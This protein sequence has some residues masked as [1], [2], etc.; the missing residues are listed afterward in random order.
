MLVAFVAVCLGIAHLATRYAPLTA[1]EVGTSVFLGVL[2]HPFG[3]VVAGDP[4]MVFYPVSEA[5]LLD[6]FTPLTATNLDHTLLLLS[7]ELA[8]VWGSILLA[9]VLTDRSV[10]PG[11]GLAYGTAAVV[12]AAVLQ[13]SS[14][15]YY[16]LAVFVGGVIGVVALAS[17]LLHGRYSPPVSAVAS[18]VRA[19]VDTIAAVS[20]LVWAMA[21]ATSVTAWG[22]PSGGTKTVV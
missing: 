1:G 13:V 21:L 8:L 19:G 20:L 15:A 2:T 12:A 3:D 11:V 16:E 14:L 7:L 18:G 10:H 4:P 22:F 17:L 5:P 6:A 9:A